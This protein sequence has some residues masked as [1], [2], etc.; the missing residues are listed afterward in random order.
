M[1]EVVLAPAPFARGSDGALQCEG[2]ALARLAEQVGTP[3]YVYSAASVRAQFAKVA[4]AFAGVPHRVHYS[5]KANSN[6]AVLSL[7]RELGAGV[8]IVSGG[9]LHRALAAGFT[10]ADV[11]FS[12]VGKTEREIHESLVSGVC[13]LN[14]ESEGELHLIDRVARALALRAPVTLRCNP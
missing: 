13:F 2:V 14:V 9:E 4:R 7:L 1:G 8:D 11:V 5:V 3:T 12:G 6:L 10:G